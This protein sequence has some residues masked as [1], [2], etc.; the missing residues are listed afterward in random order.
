M[1]TL[2]GEMSLEPAYVNQQLS[3]TQGNIISPLELVQ[4]FL[5]STDTRIF[6]T[7][8]GGMGKSTLSK[9]LISLLT[10]PRVLVLSHQAEL[11]VQEIDLRGYSVASLPSSQSL[12]PSTIVVIDGI[13]EIDP[14]VLDAYMTSLAH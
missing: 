7:A 12:D 5:A 14:E 10:D 9:N 2:S 6:I 4:E 3:D 8:G 11:R 1:K 13:D